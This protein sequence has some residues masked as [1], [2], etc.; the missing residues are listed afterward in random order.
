MLLA[1]IS[2]I[3]GVIAVNYFKID[4]QLRLV[5]I[6]N[7]AAICVVLF[8]T[9]SLVVKGVQLLR[10]KWNAYSLEQSKDIMR[11][12]F[13]FHML[14]EYGIDCRDL[15]KIERGDPIRILY[16]D[17]NWQR[18]IEKYKYSWGVPRSEQKSGIDI[19]DV[20]HSKDQLCNV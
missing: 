15:T 10:A 3:A 9:V 4:I 20:L 18:S 14:T 16:N 19:Y 17:V 12:M 13:I 7:A 1:F 2:A 5:D 11:L 6:V 8:L